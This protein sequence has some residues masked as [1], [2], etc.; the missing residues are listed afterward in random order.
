MNKVGLTVIIMT[1]MLHQEV[2]PAKFLPKVCHKVNGKSMIEI[3]I[4]TSLKLNPTNIILYVSKN[5]IECINKIL[6]HNDYFKLISFC[7]LDNEK[8]KRRMSASKCFANKNVLVIP[9]NCPLLTYKS[10]YKLVSENQ[11]VKIKNNLFYLRMENLSQIDSIDKLPETHIIPE[12]ELKQVETKADLDY[13]N[14][15]F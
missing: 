11:T 7:I 12:N 3:A 5:N 13:V 6:K 4:E 15:Q 1:F 2:K 9:G 14:S 10:L 8:E